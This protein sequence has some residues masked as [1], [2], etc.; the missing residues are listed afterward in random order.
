M[1]ANSSQLY[2][3]ESDER[4]RE[5]YRTEC[6]LEACLHEERLCSERIAYKDQAVTAHKQDME[7]YHRQL[8]T[9]PP[10]SK[11]EQEQ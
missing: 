6:W 9:A 11:T 5:K 1:L 8:Q 3:L 4:E 10:M 7:E 2:Q